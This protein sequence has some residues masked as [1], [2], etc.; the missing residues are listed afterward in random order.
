MSITEPTLT[1]LRDYYDNTDLSD[2]LTTAEIDTSTD[3]DPMVGITIRFPASELSQVPM[4]LVAPRP[5]H[6]WARRTSHQRTDVT[7]ARIK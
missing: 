6:Q 5:P 2:A 3:A 4:G 7:W 1:A